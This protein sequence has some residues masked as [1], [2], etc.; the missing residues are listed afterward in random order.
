MGDKTKNLFALHFGVNW[1]LTSWVLSCLLSRYTLAFLQ[2]FYR[3]A[4]AAIREHMS[5][6]KY[7]VFCDA[8]ELNIW[9]DFLKE[10]EGIVLDTH[11]LWMPLTKM[12]FQSIW[13]DIITVIYIVVHPNRM[14]CHYGL[15]MIR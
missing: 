1:Y 9:D 7:V 6:E 8:F 14:V 11:L 12:H 4:Y 5:A 10:F 2:Q 13:Y 3:D 15:G